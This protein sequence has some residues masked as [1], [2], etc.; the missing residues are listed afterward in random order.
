VRPLLE[1]EAQRSLDLL[2]LS[3]PPRINADIWGNFETASRT[4]FR[5]EIALTNFAFRGQTGSVAT[6]SLEFT[7]NRLRI[8]SPRLERG[9][10][11]LTADELLADFD[12]RVVNVTNGFSTAEPQAVAR[13]IG[14]KVGAAI[15][16]YR[17]ERPPTIRVNGAIPMREE[18]RADL[19]FDIEGDVFHWLRFHMS[20]I[21]GR[22]HWT[23]LMLLMTGVSADYHGGR[24]TGNAALNFPPGEGTD[25]QF[26]ASF[27]NVLLQAMMSDLVQGT[28]RLEGTL[29][30]VLHVSRGNS[31]NW[32]RSDGYG[33]VTL[34]D[35]L[36]WDIPLF[37]FF[38]PIL[39][40]LIPGLGNSRARDATATFRLMNGVFQTDDLDIR[41]TGV[42]LEYRGSLDVDGQVNAKVDAVLLRDMWIF[43]PILSTALIPLSKV[44]EYRVTG[45][46]LNLKAEPVYLIPKLVFLPLKPFQV[47]RDLLPKDSKEQS[48][49]RRST[50]TPAN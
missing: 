47:L 45:H 28:N 3:Q 31:T 41:T 33:S 50:G 14:E 2:C 7:N 37:G 27:T 16:P 36:I 25:F 30:G 23:G 18:N 34:H 19:F 42:R 8:L 22:L 11:L 1:P 39:N 17:F 32:P 20:R 15:E 5:A 38:S 49:E 21:S 48:A 4:G 10:E 26:T 35:G 13:A 43:G 44:F 46:L 29:G 6:A 40:S 9:R 12:A 24:L